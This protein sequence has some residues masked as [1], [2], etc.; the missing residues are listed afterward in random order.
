VSSRISD[1]V[2]IG[3]ERH[4]NRV[5]WPSAFSVATW[6]PLL[7]KCTFAPPGIGRT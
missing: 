4:R 1:P 5:T 6:F 2:P 7:S 3:T